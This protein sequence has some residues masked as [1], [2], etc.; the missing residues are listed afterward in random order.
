MDDVPVGLLAHHL[1]FICPHKCEN[2]CTI[3]TSY[4]A[5]R[6]MV[7][8]IIHINFAIVKGN[9]FKFFVRD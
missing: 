5:L 4:F 9:C 8:E 1:F 6:M 3:S 2:G 7:I